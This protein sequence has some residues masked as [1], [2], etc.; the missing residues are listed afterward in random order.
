MDS[1]G[2]TY[3]SIEAE[4][5]SRYASEAD[6]HRDETEFPEIWWTLQ[7]QPDVNASGLDNR[8]AFMM[9]GPHSPFAMTYLDMDDIVHPPDDGTTP[10][11]DYDFTVPETG[12]YYVWMRAQGGTSWWQDD[13]DP[14]TIEK[15][16][17]RRRVY[18][19][20]DDTPMA[21][22]ETPLHGPYGSGCAAHGDG[23]GCAASPDNWRW[24]RVLELPDL[25]GPDKVYKLNFWAAGSGFSLDKIVITN[26]PALEPAPL[27]W[28][29]GGGPGETHGRNGWACREEADDPRFAP[30]DP[31]SGELDELYDDYQPVRDAKEAAKNFVRRLDPELDQ[32]GYVVYNDKAKIKEELYC[33]KK[34]GSCEGFERIYDVI[35]TTSAKGN[36]NIADA[37]WDGLRVL[38]TGTEPEP[39]PDGRGFPPKVPGRM[40]YGRPNAAHIMILLTDGQANFYPGMVYDEKIIS[41]F[42]DGY[43]NCYSDDLWP[44]QSD[45]DESEN[46]RLARECVVWFAHK[47]RDRGVVIYT[48]GLGAQAD[49]DL[50]EHVAD[51]TGGVHSYAPKADD[52]DA[53]FQT[54][55]KNIFLRLTE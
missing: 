39:D 6:Y 8:G 18:V 37:M 19:G 34:L 51:I 20:R 47:A 27:S 14:L 45:E 42:P 30:V 29:D 40:H 23:R 53:I 13:K 24:T 16:V 50:L 3:L 38:T 35:E 1:G 49:N 21:V 25:E 7:R 12:T 15:A 31:E 41:P 2:Y 22:G 46:E 4:H 36:T 32:V 28:K 26:D 54:L 52:L 44:D 17:A 33:L 5:Y 48:I 43:A 9:V 11:L 10:R 55:Y